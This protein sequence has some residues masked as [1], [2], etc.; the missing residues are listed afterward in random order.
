MSDEN[1]GGRW[2]TRISGAFLT[3]RSHELGHREFRLFLILDALA[4]SSPVCWPCNDTLAKMMG[5]CSSSMRAALHCLEKLRWIARIPDSRS[6]DGRLGFVL[7]VRACDDRP[8]WA[9]D[10]PPIEAAELV[11]PAGRQAAEAAARG[12]PSARHTPPAE[13]SAPPLPRTRHQNRFNENKTQC[14]EQTHTN[15]D[16]RAA[17][18]GQRIVRFAREWFTE[19]QAA[20]IA[21]NLDDTRAAFGGDLS[22]YSSA[23]H[24]AHLSNSDPTRE[25]ISSPHRWAMT[26]AMA[27]RERHKLHGERQERTASPALTRA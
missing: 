26:R 15:T 21:S 2:W 10:R 22:W 5:T 6:P 8:A 13:E 16:G 1:R 27:E 9:A 19:K 23:L 17:M 24:H 12:V 14:G 3:S 25:K 7:F 4:G 11:R 18:D 20:A